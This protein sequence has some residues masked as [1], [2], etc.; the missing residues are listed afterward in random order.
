MKTF[1][2]LGG[3]ISFSPSAEKYQDIHSHYLGLSLICTRMFEEHYNEAAKDVDDALD[4]IKSG[5]RQ[6]PILCLLSR[7]KI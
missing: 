6:S 7:S 3:E 5:V 1:K 2:I 4:S